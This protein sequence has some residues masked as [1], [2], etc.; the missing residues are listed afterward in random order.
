LDLSRIRALILDI[1]GVLWRSTT[2]IG[3]L[4]AIFAR[5][6]A[7]GL[8]VMMATNNATSNPQQYVE[9]LADFGVSVGIDQIINSGMATAHYLKK[10]YPEGGQVFV[11]GDQPLIDLL[12]TFGFEHNRHL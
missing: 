4:A 10:C 9:K 1:D 12:A 5:I 7:L 3:D 8:Q 2:P 11:V 6:A